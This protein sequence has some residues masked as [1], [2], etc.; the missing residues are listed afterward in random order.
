MQRHSLVYKHFWEQWVYGLL[1]WRT[2]F[3]CISKQKGCREAQASRFNL[4]CEGFFHLFE[5]KVSSGAAANKQFWRILD[6][7]YNN[8]IIW[9]S[10]QALVPDCVSGPLSQIPC[11]LD[12]KMDSPD[13]WGKLVKNALRRAASHSMLSWRLARA[14][15][16]LTSR[17][18]SFWGINLS[19][20]LPVSTSDSFAKAALN[21]AESQRD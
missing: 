13:V 12:V 11:G 9:A 3:F 7:V 20:K 5:S 10:L 16:S 6:C 21:D 17:R 2:V 15:R 18:I 1:M 4:E 19:P 14:F 8:Q